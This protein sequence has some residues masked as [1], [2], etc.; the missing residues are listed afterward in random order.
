MVKP[1]EFETSDEMYITWN[2]YK[3]Y[4]DMRKWMLACIKEG[5]KY[6]LNLWKKNNKNDLPLY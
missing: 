4:A 5:W 2:P 1:T 3:T 6:A